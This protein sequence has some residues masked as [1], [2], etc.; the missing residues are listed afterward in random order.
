MVKCAMEMNIISLSLSPTISVCTLL[1][2]FP[3]SRR[4]IWLYHINK[5]YFFSLFLVFLILFYHPSPYPHPPLSFS[6]R[7]STFESSIECTKTDYKINEKWDEQMDGRKKYDTNWW[8][9]Q[10]I[11]TNYACY[12]HFTHSSKWI[13]EI[14]TN[15]FT[16][17]KESERERDEAN[18]FDY[19]LFIQIISINV[20]LCETT[21]TFK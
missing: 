3:F 2:F 13:T 6:H 11:A 18:D 7:L 4:S 19:G 17:E 12:K 9:L 8:Q 15:I 21:C 16:T 10:T 14:D 1:L 20:S 5:Y